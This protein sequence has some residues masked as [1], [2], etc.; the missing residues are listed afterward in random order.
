MK[1]LKEIPFNHELIG[2]EGIVVKDRNGEQPSQIVV[3]KKRLENLNEYPIMC[4]DD[5]G[6]AV[7]YTLKGKYTLN[8]ESDHDLTMY[9][10][11]EQ[12]EPRVI[13]GVES[14]D[15][16]ILCKPERLQAAQNIIN[17]F[18]ITERNDYKIIKF[19][20]VIEEGE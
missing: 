10:E 9:Q 6:V 13:W 4:F 3:V 20:E 11:V 2:Q 7:S 15:G 14:P 5:R 8:N 17:S 18:P 19:I 16:T 1:K 12:K